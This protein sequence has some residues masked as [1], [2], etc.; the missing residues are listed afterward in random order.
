MIKSKI[1]SNIITEYL[2][3]IRIITEDK[4]KNFDEILVERAR[5]VELFSKKR[6][7][8]IEKGGYIILDFGCEIQGGVVITI[9]EAPDDTHLRIVFGESV[10]ESMSKIGEKNATN[11]HAIRDMVWP[12]TCFQ[13]FRAGN[14]GFRFV[15]IETLD[16]PVTISGVQAAFEHRD[17]EKKGSFKCSD[18]LLNK[19]WEVGAYTV[20]LNMQEYLWDGIKRD[21]L[22][23]VGDMHPEVKTILS[24]YGDNE[25]IKK[26]LDFMTDY[27]PA[28]EWMNTTPSYNMWWLKI[29]YDYYMWSGDYAYLESQKD[30][31]FDMTNHIMSMINPDGTHNVEAIFTEWNSHETPWE[32]AGFQAILA[33]GIDSAGKL[34]KL[35]ANDD[36]SSRC[37]VVSALVKKNVYPYEGNKQIA[38]MLVLADMVDAK[39]IC[40][41]VIKP[42]DAKGISTFWGYY[43]LQALA[44]SGDFDSALSI[45]KGFWGKMLELGATSFW[46]DFDVSWAD[47]GARID[48]LVP[49]GKVDVHGDYGKFCYQGFRHS[50]CH[51]WASG[52]TA[53]MSEHILGIK[54][55]DAGC[56]KI[57]IKPNMG[58]LEWA[59]GSFPTP[60]GEVTVEHKQKDGRVET[61]YSAPG[62]IEVILG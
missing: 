18:N 14:T 33:I 1:K 9:T 28:D 7:L 12:V 35:L 42:G 53:F 29:Q 11:N 17:I 20:F 3:P 19:I 38:A 57:T 25:V 6:S 16:N 21:R 5:Q 22:V 2:M 56:K 54:I 61:T 44:K 47:D 62:E 39:I 32:K 4:C 26:S 48:E 36:L 15:K 13:T 24:A 50:L 51:G 31:I 10:S 40:D 30:Y 46:E 60:F 55:L 37:E 59:R 45:I 23:W 43:S 49:E 41:D 52:P 58:G 27:T 34:C 8:E